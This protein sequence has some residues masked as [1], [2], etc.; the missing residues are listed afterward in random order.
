MHISYD[1]VAPEKITYY[2]L[3]PQA[4]I[5]AANAEI[6]GHAQGLP[7]AAISGA[8]QPVV[9]K[10]TLDALQKIGKVGSLPPL[11]VFANRK[12]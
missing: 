1:Q 9:R 4:A 5:W 11:A 7:R 6:D 2:S 12:N 8:I 3:L 10:R